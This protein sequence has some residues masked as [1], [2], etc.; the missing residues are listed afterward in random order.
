MRFFILVDTISLGYFFADM[1]FL[2]LIK[3]AVF[4]IFPDMKFAIC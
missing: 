1:K 3:N 4:Q 2:I